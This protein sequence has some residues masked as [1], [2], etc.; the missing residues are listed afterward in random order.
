MPT[1]TR[2]KKVARTALLSKLNEP[3]ENDNLGAVTPEPNL[4]NIMRL[5]VNA[6]KHGD[7]M[8]LQS[9]YGNQAV[10]RLLRQ[11]QAGSTVQRL[12][13]EGQLR[14]LAGEPKSDKK[15]GFGKLSKIHK[16]SS[17]YKNVLAAVGTANQKLDLVVGS[18]EKIYEVLNALEGVM[19]TGNAYLKK[20]PNDKKRSDHIRSVVSQAGAEYDILYKGRTALGPYAGVTFRQAIIQ[21]QTTQI[22]QEKEERLAPKI[23]EGINSFESEFV[24][25]SV[26]SQIKSLYEREDKDKA[27]VEEGFKPRNTEQLNKDATDERDRIFSSPQ[28]LYNRMETEVKGQIGGAKDNSN[29]EGTNYAQAF[30]G[31]TVASSLMTATGA[32]FGMAYFRTTVLPTLVNTIFHEKSTE[33][34]PNKKGEEDNLEENVEIVRGMYDELMSSF[35]G[36]ESVTKVPDEIKKASFM[37]F[38]AIKEKGGDDPDAFKMVSSFIFLRFINPVITQIASK[39]GSHGSRTL[40]LLTKILQNQANKI[41]FDKKEAF[42]IVFNTS[43]E[44]YAE[45]MDTFILGVVLAGQKLSTN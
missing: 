36:D 16:M 19:R 14:G 42:M 11:N 22:R 5:P 17:L 15:I 26:K 3:H 21:M 41:M 2:V 45:A 37:M 4:A 13:T 27:K 34:D 39:L 40:I 8:T 6:L 1:K 25:T 31:N 35:T 44:K 30:R 33:V 29:T 32:K 20:H 43:L 38:Q 28:N 23:E 12:M 18:G 10:Q 24:P 9:T 7:F